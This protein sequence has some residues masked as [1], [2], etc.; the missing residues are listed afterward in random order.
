[1]EKRRARSSADHKLVRRNGKRSAVIWVMRAVETH[2]IQIHQTPICVSVRVERERWKNKDR[3]QTH[4]RSIVVL[5]PYCERLCIKS[6]L[7]IWLFKI[8]YVFVTLYFLTLLSARL[9][10][11][12]YLFIYF[13]INGQQVIIKHFK[14]H[15]YKTIINTVVVCWDPAGSGVM[16]LTPKLTI[17]Q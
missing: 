5:G 3:K 2:Q 7:R 17:F 1:M 9:A 13:K 11:F 15:C 12:F 4:T 10:P 14:T 16:A 8:Y 6:Q